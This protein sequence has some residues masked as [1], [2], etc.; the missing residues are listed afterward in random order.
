MTSSSCSVCGSVET[1]IIDGL[2][3]CAVCGTQIFDY[4]ELEADDDRV[5]IGRAKIAKRKD[6]DRPIRSEGNL[7]SAVLGLST[8]NVR[9]RR[10]GEE[11]ECYLESSA[12]KD[13]KDSS[14]ILKDI[15]T[16]QA[17]APTYLKSVGRRL[18]A[19]TKMLAKGGHVFALYQRYL[20]ACNVAYTAKDYTEDLEEMFRAV[21][22]NKDSASERA[23]EKKNK[24]ERRKERGQE[25]LE[26]STTAWDLLMSD[27]VGENLDIQ[28]DSAPEDEFDPEKAST[29]RTQTK[30][31]LV[32]V[33]DTMVPK[34]ILN[35][36]TSFYLAVDV[37]VA[38]L[39]ISLITAGCRWI[40]LSDIIRWVREGRFGISVFQLAALRSGR[41]EKSKKSEK[42]YWTKMNIPLYEFHRTLLFIWQICRLPSTPVKVDFEQIVAR[43][44]YH[45][46]LPRA[47]MGRVLL[48]IEKAPP[49]VELDEKSLRRQG[50]IEHMV[51]VFG[52][53][54]RDGNRLNTD[55]FFS[56]ETKAF[57]YILM[58]LKLCFGL[59]GVREFDVHGNADKLMNN[60]YSRPVEPLLYEKDFKRVPLRRQENVLRTF[61]SRPHTQEEKDEIRT[62]TD[63]LAVKTFRADFDEHILFPDTS[64][65]NASKANLAQNES[66][67]GGNRIDEW[68]SYFPC[69]KGY[70]GAKTSGLRM[71]FAS[72][73]AAIDA[74]EC[75]QPAMSH[76]FSMLIHWFSKIIGESELVL[77]CA[78]MMLELQI[79]DF[80]KFHELRRAMVDGKVYPLKTTIACVDG[81]RLF[82]TL[83]VSAAE[84]ISD[85]S[86]IDVVRI[87]VPRDWGVEGGLDGDD[88]SDD[89]SSNSSSELYSET[90]DSDI[91]EVMWPAKNLTIYRPPLPES[92]LLPPVCIHLLTYEKLPGISGM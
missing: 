58:A 15:T 36:A 59:D 68:Y 52:R 30:S 89:Y 11:L 66:A 71:L 73:K 9:K 79:V 74:W 8:T 4:R 16:G 6:A 43:L 38:L 39:F 42:S 91:D 49:C 40:L 35:N 47:M 20:S 25:A 41:L 84:D 57:A 69:A 48:L 14:E 28:S 5:V 88:E 37:L 45:L 54:L 72:R 34:K 33:V 10:K 81:R 56:T 46:N 19:F 76:T 24:K 82:K 90:T 17:H 53:P 70:E 27:T 64:S 55:I 32:Q 51:T 62:S 92:V 26:K 7:E 44:L 13:S 65:S 75:A 78:F 21:V 29:A 2:M 61:L 60:C 86:E 87:G 23:K 3:Y 22:V 31:S 80:K 85:A 67:A 50:S 18:C 12:T 83:Y 1:E 63:E 77:Y